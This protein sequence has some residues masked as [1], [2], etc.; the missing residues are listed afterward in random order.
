MTAV[1][2]GTNVPLQGRSVTFVLQLL[3]FD[4]QPGDVQRVLVQLL[5]AQDG[6]DAGVSAIEHFAPFFLRP[7]Y[8][9]SSKNLTSLLPPN[10]PSINAC[11]RDARDTNEMA[12]K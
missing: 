2:P 6:G 12:A 1:L 11:K 5:R 9:D 7:L 8:E 4:C 3:Q 10:E